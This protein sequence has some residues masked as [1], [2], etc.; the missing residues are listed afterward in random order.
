MFIL[1]SSV[2]YSAIFLSLYFVNGGEPISQGEYMMT[3]CLEMTR[4]CL[5]IDRKSRK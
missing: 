2:L 1:C 3:T 4:K 5:R